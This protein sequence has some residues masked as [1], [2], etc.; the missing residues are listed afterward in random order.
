L[1]LLDRGECPVG[2]PS[3]LPRF[4]G[5]ARRPCRDDCDDAEKRH[6]PC[7]D[8]PTASARAAVSFLVLGKHEIRLASSWREKKLGRRS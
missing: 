6:R 7:N 5:V 1:L 3:G 4:D 8:E 2:V